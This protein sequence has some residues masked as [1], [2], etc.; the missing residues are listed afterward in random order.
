MSNGKRTVSGLINSQSAILTK[1]TALS[2]NYG[3][4]SDIRKTPIY[5]QL[6]IENIQELWEKFSVN[7]SLI[8]EHADP[9]DPEYTNYLN[10]TY[11]AV[12]DI[13]NELKN[14]VLTKISEVTPPPPLPTP[15]IPGNIAINADVQLAKINIPVFSGTYEAW[16]GFHDLYVAL[17]H[18]NASLSNV[19]KLYHLKSN[20][21]GEASSLI[22]HLEPTDANYAAAWMILKDRYENLRVLVFTQIKRLVSQPSTSSDSAVSIKKTS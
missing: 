8:S 22:S 2:T 20:I 10:V 6:K 18:N 14:K 13:R 15:P 21:S 16:K 19:Q 1:F 5:L 11:N 17:I 4:D 12:S 3:K 9:A 7:D